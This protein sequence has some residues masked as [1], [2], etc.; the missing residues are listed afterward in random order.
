MV[1]NRYAKWLKTCHY[2][3]RITAIFFGSKKTT[4]LIRFRTIMLHGD[5]MAII[6]LPIKI[7]DLIFN[8]Y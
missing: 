6:I 7:D 2:D 5:G 8:L 3:N 1:H 4:S